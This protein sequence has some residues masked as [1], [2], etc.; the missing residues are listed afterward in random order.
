[1][2]A[3]FRQALGSGGTDVRRRHEEQRQRRPPT[4]SNWEAPDSEGKLESLSSRPEV[5]V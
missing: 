5:W 1:M 4:R 3:L 2:A